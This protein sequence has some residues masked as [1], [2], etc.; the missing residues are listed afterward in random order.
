VL[1]EGI[2]STANTFKVLCFSGEKYVALFDYVAQY[3]DELSFS[4]RIDLFCIEFSLTYSISPSCCASL[5][6]I[7][8]ICEIGYPLFWKK[9][10]YK[11][12]AASVSSPMQ[13]EDCEI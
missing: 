12:V 13:L 5:L 3:E 6:Y 11:S 9:S 1:T 7:E 2:S 10:A 4:V 8:K